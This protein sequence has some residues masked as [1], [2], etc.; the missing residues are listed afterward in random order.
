MLFS[1]TYGTFYI[2]DRMQ[3]A[4]RDAVRLFRYIPT[5]EE[6]KSET[7]PGPGKPKNRQFCFDFHDFRPDTRSRAPETSGNVVFAKETLKLQNI[8]KS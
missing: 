1:D 4:Q 5:P 7:H 2:K 8:G 6:E 3:N